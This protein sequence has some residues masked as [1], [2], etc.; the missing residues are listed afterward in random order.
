MDQRCNECG[1]DRYLELPGT[2]EVTARRRTGLAHASTLVRA[3]RVLMMPAFATLTVCCS[4]TSWSCA[5]H[6]RVHR[7]DGRPPC[8]CVR[9]LRHN[10]HFVWPLPSSHISTESGLDA[11]TQ[12]LASL[13]AYN[14]WAGQHTMERALSDILS[15]SSM[16]QTPWSLSTSAPLSNTISRVSGSCQPRYRQPL[17][18][19]CDYGIL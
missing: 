3:L 5:A 10:V 9:E 6:R 14:N 17:R 15:N 13:L 1:V 12:P 11:A 4:I 19:G 2:C 16:Q 7:H 8:V 18:H